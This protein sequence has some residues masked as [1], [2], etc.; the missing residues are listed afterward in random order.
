[1]LRASIRQLCEADHHG[2]EAPLALWLANKTAA[3]LARWIGDPGAVLLVADAGDALAAV[4]AVRR[5]GEITLNYVAPEF[6]FRGVSTAMVA[7][8]EA[9]A[10]GLGLE[11]VRLSNTLTAHAFYLARGWR[12]SGPPETKHGLLNYPMEKALT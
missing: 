9:E 12:D 8:L 6:R 5:D 4:G 1:M 3:N 2:A 10:R 11:R 7:A